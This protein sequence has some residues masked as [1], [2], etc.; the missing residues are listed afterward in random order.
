MQHT[1]QTSAGAGWGFYVAVG[2]VVAEGPGFPGANG[3]W[4]V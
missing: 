1:E 3:C 4:L 2:D